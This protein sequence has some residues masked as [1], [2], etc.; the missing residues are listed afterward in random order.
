VIPCTFIGGYYP[1][2]GGVVL[3]RNIGNHL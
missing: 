2:D 3:L 1:E